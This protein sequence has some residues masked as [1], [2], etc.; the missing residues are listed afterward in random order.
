MRRWPR[1]PSGGS[2]HRSIAWY[3]WPGGSGKRLRSAGGRRLRPGR[4]GRPGLSRLATD[5]RQALPRLVR[6]APGA[7]L[8]PP[9]AGRRG[10]RTGCLAGVAGMAREED[11]T[12]NGCVGPG[13][14]WAVR[15]P[16]PDRCRERVVPARSGRGHRARVGG[17]DDLGSG[18]GDRRGGPRRARWGMET[19][20]RSSETA[21]GRSVGVRAALAAYYHL[22]KPRI[23]LL[24]LITTVP[25]MVLA[26]KGLPSL[27]LIAA[28]LIGG[29]QSAGGGPAP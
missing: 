27:W 23:V 22:T 29:G 18:R 16:D 17:G 1:S 13:R 7:P 19:K 12:G 26:D 9:G 2:S 6:V 3:G 4:G 28:T 10:V 24:L 20:G 5:E 8:R 14:R 21:H 25:S 15:G 11:T